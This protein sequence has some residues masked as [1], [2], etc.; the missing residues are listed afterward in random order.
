VQ[1]YIWRDPLA[2]DVS[3]DRPIGTLLPNRAR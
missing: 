3:M 2:Q 1:G